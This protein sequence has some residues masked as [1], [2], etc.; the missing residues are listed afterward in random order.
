[1]KK[2]ACIVLATVVLLL[3][4]SLPSQAHFRG[5]IW[6]GPVWGPG[7]WGPAY[8]YSYA[9]PYPYYA[10]PPTVIRQEPEEYVQP[11]PQ[12]E[13]QYWYYCPDP[14]GY[15]PYV[16]KCPKGWMKVAPEPTPPK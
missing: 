15:Y 2:T 1:M 8:S 16:A 13:Q 5:G 14:Q 4:H 12:P 11:A 10:P 7:W 9:Y 3:A 6:I